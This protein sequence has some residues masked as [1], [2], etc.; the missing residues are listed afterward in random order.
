[1]KIMLTLF[2]VFPGILHVKVAEFIVCS[3]SL[4][5]ISYMYVAPLLLLLL[6]T[7]RQMATTRNF[8]GRFFFSL[9]FARFVVTFVNSLLQYAEILFFLQI[10]I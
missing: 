9:S 8:F 1:M 10:L 7:N 3:L 2:Q 5:V 4:T 6:H